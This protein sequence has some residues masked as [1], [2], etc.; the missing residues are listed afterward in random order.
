MLSIRSLTLLVAPAKISPGSLQAQ[1]ERKPVRE[2][3]GGKEE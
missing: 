3:G 1:K 2:K